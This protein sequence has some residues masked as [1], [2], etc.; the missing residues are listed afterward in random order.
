MTPLRPLLICTPLLLTSTAF[1][2]DY[3]A[4][5]DVEDHA[6]M[7]GPPVSANQGVMT[8]PRTLAP[9]A[10]AEAFSPMKTANRPC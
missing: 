9:A 2:T 8:I 10:S 6:L 4:C 7:E 1:A 5:C 3:V